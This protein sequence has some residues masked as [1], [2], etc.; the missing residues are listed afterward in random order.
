MRIALAEKLLV[1]I[2]EWT[3]EEVQTERPM[4]QA[5]ANFKYDEYQQFSPGMRFIE[6]LVRWLKQF[7]TKREK[8]IAYEF[9]K[10]KLIFISGE[11]ILHLV[12]LG[13]TAIVRPVLL[14]KTATELR[15]SKHSVHLIASSEEYKRNARRTLFIGLSDGSRIDHFRRS[16]A[17]NNEQVLPTY[18]I[19]EFKAQDMMSEL[20]K[21]TGYAQ[22]NSVFLID[23]FTASGRSYCRMNSGK[24]AGKVLKFLC[25]IFDIEQQHKHYRELI[26]ENELTV[27][28]LFYIATREALDYIKGQVDDWATAYM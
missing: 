10:S 17:I 25:R 15:V 1:K 14:E 19:S 3:P 13:F 2:M 8:D 21:S 12:G 4:L 18:E 20:M 5:L 22:F 7:G 9:I 26:C 27:N 24:P 23:D 11:Q 6:S 28:L 16:A